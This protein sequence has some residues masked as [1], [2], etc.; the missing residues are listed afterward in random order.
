[1]NALIE[2]SSKTYRERMERWVDVALEEGVRFFVT[3][4]GNPRWVVE[5]VHAAGG[6]VYHDVTERKWAQKGLR[7]RRRRADRGERPAPAGTPGRASARA[8][9]DELAPFGLPV[10]CAGGVGDARDFV[11]A[12]RAGLCRRPARHALHR[13]PRVPGAARPTS[14]RSS[15]R[16]EKRH[17]PHRAHHRRAGR[18]DRHAL[19]PARSGTQAGRAR[20]LPAARPPHASTGCGRSTRCARSGR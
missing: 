18:G 7:R 1:M 16:R 14:G 17:R 4:L 19:R 3:S 11:A 13:D 10:V 6:V 12:L 5:R 20:A 9:L 8:L 15:T 2:Q